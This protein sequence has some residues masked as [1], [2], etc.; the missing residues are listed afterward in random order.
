VAGGNDLSVVPNLVW[1]TDAGIQMNP[2]SYLPDTYDCGVD[3]SRLPVPPPGRKGFPINEVLCTQNAGCNYNCGWCGGSR[4][5]FRRIYPRRCG[6]ARKPKRT[7]RQ[8]LST[9]KSNSQVRQLHYY[10]V[11]SY[12]ESGND[13]GSFVE[14]IAEINLK[15]ISYEQ[16]H[17]TPE[18]LL[19]KMVAANKATSI[20]LSP[21]SHDPEI[22]KLC[23][24]GVY[25]NDEMERWIEKALEVGIAQIDIWYFC[26]M[27]GQTKDSVFDTVAYCKRLLKKFQ[28]ARVNPM[29]CPMV[30]FLDPA[31]TFFE[32]PDEHGF[33]VFFKTVEDHANGM[34]RASIINRMNYETKY[35]TREEIVLVGFEATRRLMEAKG[36]FGYMPGSFLNPYIDKIKDAIDFTRVVH[37]ADSL[38]Q[39]GERQKA[40]AELGD[41]I[42]LRNNNIIFSGV[43]NQA[44][45][46]NRGIGGR[47]FDEFGWDFSDLDHAVNGE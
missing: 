43:S 30:P 11:G 18:P 2:F 7:T 22:A 45:P 17:L 47:W 5:A 1:K 21:E 19:Q 12:N 33:R 36:E 4:E 25:S 31:S 34:T 24:R 13:L 32:E 27:P 20:T 16:F 40:L 14:Q 28:G 8:E 42:L 46:I 9:L 44:F 3:W 6:I 38:T 26:G 35:M 39:P 23:G 10:A 29:I 15:S 41:E 37:E